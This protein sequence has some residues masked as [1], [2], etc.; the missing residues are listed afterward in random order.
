MTSPGVVLMVPGAAHIERCVKGHRDARHFKDRRGWICSHCGR[1][2]VWDDTW[3]YYGNLECRKCAR[4]AID[5]VACSERCRGICE[6]VTSEPEGGR[7]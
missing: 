5:F 6:D 1:R 2:G 7:R 4:A 3:S